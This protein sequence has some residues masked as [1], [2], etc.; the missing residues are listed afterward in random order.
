MTAAFTSVSLRYVNS[1]SA[2][3]VRGSKHVIM[4]QRGTS[5]MF[6]LLLKIKVLLILRIARLKFTMLFLCL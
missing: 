4:C 1:M 6:N 2:V 3:F 5:V